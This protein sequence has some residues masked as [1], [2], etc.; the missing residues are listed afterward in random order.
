M[1]GAGD[2]NPHAGRPFDD[3]DDAIA[4]A[5]ED[6]S[7]PALL[8]SLVHITGDPSWVRGDLRPQGAMLNEYQGYMP[9]E[10]QAEARRL[11]LPVI[12]AYRDGGCV[13]PPPPST[14]RSSFPTR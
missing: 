11:A 8:C 4:A 2:R 3:D 13:L 12:A 6:V 1:A 7:V 5:L 9:P 10:M 14:E